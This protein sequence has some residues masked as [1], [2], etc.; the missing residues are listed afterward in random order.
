MT[1][2]ADINLLSL[3]G[4]AALFALGMRHGLDPDHI[5]VIDGMTLKAHDQCRAHAKW[6]GGLFSL[7]HG[8]VVIV[9]AMLSAALASEVTPPKIV[10]M[11]AQW[12]PLLFLAWVGV[13]NL[14]ALLRP[15]DFSPVSVRSQWVPKQWRERTDPLGIAIVG[16]FFATVVDTLALA[17]AW[18]FTAVEHGGVWAGFVVG[19]AFTA[20][21]LATGTADSWLVVYLSGQAKS[22]AAKQ[23]YRRGLGWLVVMLAFSVVTW[24]LLNITGLK[25]QPALT[26]N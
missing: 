2:L 5:A 25:L 6:T 24:N 4:I 8:V 19:V 1:A 11:V 21:M 22:A 13:A 7:G 23:R 12:L 15:A 14:R 10:L 18:G 9:L 17:A 26:S 16:V 20:G 3:S